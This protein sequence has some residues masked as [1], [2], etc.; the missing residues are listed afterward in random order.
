MTKARKKSGPLN[1]VEKAAIQGMLSQ[2]KSIG[3]IASTLERSES[4]VDNYIN[5]ELDELHSTIVNAKIQKEVKR[6]SSPNKEDIYNQQKPS[7]TDIVS[8]KIVSV[9]H[10]R[11][12]QA[13]LKDIDANKVIDMAIDRYAQKN[14]VI[15]DEEELYAESIKSMKAGE[16]MIKKSAGGSDGVAIMT[17]AASQR[18]DK[19]A[20]TQH[21][22]PIEKNIFRPNG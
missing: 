11:L 18:G 16:F 10:K 4:I 14:K 22:N 6:W 20:R 19:P 17:P 3:E 12:Q 7:S 9:V 2:E 8:D 1:L 21:S 13:G 5:N 15:K